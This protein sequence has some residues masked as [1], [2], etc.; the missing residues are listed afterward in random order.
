MDFS[1]LAN[2][3]KEEVF[4]Q[5]V[6]GGFDSRTLISPAFAYP[7]DFR[8]VTP[9]EIQDIVIP[10]TWVAQYTGLIHGIGAWFDINLGGYILSTA[11]HAEKT[12]WHQVRLMLR[13]IYI[14][15][16]EP[17]AVNAFETVSGWMR[18]VANPMRSYDIRAEIVLGSTTLS[19]PYQEFPKDD[20]RNTPEGYSKRTGS[21]ALH[22]QTYYFDQPS[23]D[24][25]TKPEYAGLYEPESQPLE[26]EF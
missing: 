25:V 2:D 24:H 14:L 18:M 20:A 4:G 1:P 6:V 7:V 22:E 9:K 10:F 15:D 5:P 3:A 8:T 17:L 19:D 23:S 26:M 11:P 13:G 21:W 16:L 12:H